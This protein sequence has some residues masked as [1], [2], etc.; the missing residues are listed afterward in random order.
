MLAKITFRNVVF[1]VL[2]AIFTLYAIDV[3]DINPKLIPL[4]LI[5]SIYL[6]SCKNCNIFSKENREE[7]SEDEKGT[8]VIPGNLKVTGKLIVDDDVTMKKT[9]TI[10]EETKCDNITTKDLKVTSIKSNTTHHSDV[11]IQNK[12]NMNKDVTIA[13][14]TKC[15]NM[16]TGN[17]VSNDITSKKI[18]ASGHVKVPS[19]VTTSCHV[20]NGINTG[21]LNVR[22]DSTF[23]GH[24][25][26]ANG[27]HIYH[28]NNSKSIY[29]HGEAKTDS[30]D[31][32]IGYE[33]GWG[34]GLNVVGIRDGDNGRVVRLHSAYLDNISNINVNDD[35][36]VGNLN[37]RGHVKAP[38]LQAMG[39]LQCHKVACANI[40]TKTL[41]VRGDSTFNGHLTVANGKHIYHKNNS[42]SIYG[43]GEAKTSVNDGSIGYE[44]GWGRGLNVVGIKDEKN[45]RVVR[46]H[47]NLLTNIGN[48]HPHAVKA[49]VIDTDQLLGHAFGAKAGDNNTIYTPGKKIHWRYD[50]D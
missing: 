18:T 32:A 24:L 22:G 15:Q 8:L 2:C 36:N 3:I 13:G 45:G 9:V 42:K 37:A 30:N 4:L 11:N 49:H 12:I 20:H 35:I 39:Q 38:S 7:F 48:I 50:R 10:N 44:A 17:I 19:L 41:N 46:L 6:L 26:V 21:T 34:I 23:N 5:V 28:K 40:D 27:K 14:N 31:G 1:I 16:D 33:A 43:H 29:G 47:S 25:T